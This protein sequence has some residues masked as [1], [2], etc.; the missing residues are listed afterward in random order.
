MRKRKN[1]KKKTEKVRRQQQRDTVKNLHRKVNDLEIQ[2]YHLRGKD[3]AHQE[4]QERAVAT[5]TEQVQKK[6][7][8]VQKEAAQV[9]ELR[10]QLSAKDKQ[11]QNTTAELA[12]VKARDAAHGEELA[13]TK[14]DAE[15]RI[16]EEMKRERQQ[17]EES[18][19]KQLKEQ[20]ERAEK[21]ELS[22]KEF[23]EKMSKG[24]ELADFIKN[25]YGPGRPKKANK[26]LNVSIP[27]VL[28][29]KYDLLILTKIIGKGEISSFITE[30]LT[31][32][33]EQKMAAYDDYINNGLKFED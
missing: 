14:A 5:A 6:L 4:E 20:T 17:S 28:K 10:Q 16:K 11:L 15:S 9:P 26:A 25:S 18:L 23:R 29:D 1:N 8:A 19:Q 30:C 2:L 22:E 21:A 27:A 32:W 7:T 31:P 24:K 13:R 12:V 33:I 3:A